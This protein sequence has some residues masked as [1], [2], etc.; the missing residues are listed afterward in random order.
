MK[1]AHIDMVVMIPRVIIV[2]G[3][4]RTDLFP[5]VFINPVFVLVGIL[6]DIDVDMVADHYFVRVLVEW[7]EVTGLVITVNVVFIGIFIFPVVAIARR[8]K[9]A[10]N[11]YVE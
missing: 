2:R 7:I 6:G 8:R 11:T 9:Q 3:W 1:A 4:V 10:I 5:G